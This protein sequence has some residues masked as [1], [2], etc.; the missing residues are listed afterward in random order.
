MNHFKELEHFDKFI[1]KISSKIMFEDIFIFQGSVPEVSEEIWDNGVEDRFNSL[2][3]DLEIKF[4]DSY[5]EHIATDQGQEDFEH[6]IFAFSNT[7]SNKTTH[8]DNNKHHHKGGFHGD[9]LV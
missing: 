6:F 2:I 1:K 8:V 7:S 4:V 5:Q 9:C 3:I